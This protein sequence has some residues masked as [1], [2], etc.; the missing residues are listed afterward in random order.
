MVFRLSNSRFVSIICRSSSAITS[1]ILYRKDTTHD[2]EHVSILRLAAK[3][4]SDYRQDTAVLA[5]VRKTRD[6]IETVE[7]RNAQHNTSNF[8]FNERRSR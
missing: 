6:V 7:A 3:L 8:S 5:H 1:L 2:Y 4:L